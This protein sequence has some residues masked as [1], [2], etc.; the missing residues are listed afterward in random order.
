METL[1]ESKVNRFVE[2]LELKRYSKNT[3]NIYLS[4]FKSFLNY[5]KGDID[6]L[7]DSDI[8]NYILTQSKN[9]SYSYQNVL[10]NTIKFYY[11]KVNYRKRRFYK[12]ERPKQERKLPQVISKEEVLKSI[13]LIPNLKHKAIISLAF[14]TGMR[15]SEICNLKIVDI[16]SKRMILRI[17]DSKGKKDRIVP[18]SESILTLLRSYWQEYKP[19]FYLFESYKPGV[20]YSTASCRQIWNKYKINKQSTFHTLRHSFATTMLENKTDIRTIQRL[21]GHS[22][23]K[24]TE[25]YTHV[26]TDYLKTLKLPI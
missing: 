11:E 22:N 9:K 23:L 20:K 17:L 2:K 19:K 6:N 16:D 14:S 4:N 18:L 25:I 24:T 15:V 21:L 7:K 13:E 1:I 12:I 5:F 10:T 26:S 8:C 3:K